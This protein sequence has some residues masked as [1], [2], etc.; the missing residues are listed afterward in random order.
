M[1]AARGAL[2]IVIA[3][4]L[5]ACQAK[6]TSPTAASTAAAA[7]PEATSEATPAEWIEQE[8]DGVLLGVEKPPGWQA[9][10]TDDGI[11][12][13][14]HF[15]SMATGGE[16][17]RGVQIHIFVH[18]LKDFQLADSPNLAWAALNQIVTNREYIGSAQANKPYGFEWSRHDAAFY[19]SN[20]GDGNMTMLIGVALSNAEQ[21]VVCNVTS[22]ASESRRIR[23]LLPNVLRTLNVNGAQMDV[24][25]LT[26][27]PDPL[28]FPPFA[29]NPKP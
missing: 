29:V 13:A 17:P 8:V 3:F 19:L 28:V 24:D 5:A 18:S 20:N 27:L 21:M 22:P 6:Y 23:A 2:L 10:K 26:Q 9:Q 14:E 12:L 25:A 11:L 1:L 4:L 7:S 16:P 15:G